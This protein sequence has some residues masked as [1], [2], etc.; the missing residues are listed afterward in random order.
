MRSSQSAFP[1]N[2]APAAQRRSWLDDDDLVAG[3][4]VP[5][6][7]RERGRSGDNN[8]RHGGEGTALAA[9]KSAAPSPLDADIGGERKMDERSDAK[10]PLPRLNHFGHR[11]EREAVDEH[12]S[13]IAKGREHL[14]RVRQG[15]RRG[16]REAVIELAD[17]DRPAKLPQPVGHAPVVDV[18]AGWS[19]EPSR[20]DEN[21]RVHSAPVTIHAWPAVLQPARRGYNAAG[22]QTA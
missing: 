5:S 2:R 22:S 3:D 4:A 14:G 9:S 6:Q 10:A 13:A 20:N 12:S 8:Q 17:L 19:V 21:R 18:T 7:H 11:A 15:G 16:I 1:Q